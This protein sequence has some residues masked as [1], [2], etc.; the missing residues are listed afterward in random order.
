[1]KEPKRE[2]TF[3]NTDD[4]EP[5]AES[6]AVPVWLVIGF[7]ILFYA[8]TMYL[9]RHAGGFKEKVYEPYP[10]LKALQASHPKSAGS[11]QFDQ[12]K[13]VYSTYCSPCHQPSGM[14]AAG[15]APP[16]VGSDWVL[17]PGAG[18][19]VR[20]ILHGLAGPIKVKG[21]D[22]NGAMVPWKDTLNDA[23]IAA[24]ATFVR[25]NKEW[26]ADH[27]APAVKPEDVKAIRDANASRAAA[28]TQAE[29]DS[30][31]PDSNQ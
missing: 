14:G 18:R 8:S 7:G 16:L 22:F 20:V 21:V 30:V 26:G 25:Q 2:P 12:G 19:M 24:V 3:R 13:K 28:W 27:A 10:S 4:L 5:Q 17:T 6:R 15:V 23:D 1:M 29:I 9:D 31:P 11:E